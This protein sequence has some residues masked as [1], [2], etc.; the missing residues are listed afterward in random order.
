MKDKVDFTNIIQYLQKKRLDLLL[1]RQEQDICISQK[2]I[3]MEDIVNHSNTTELFKTD[4]IVKIENEIYE[5][6]TRLDEINAE[7]SQIDNFITNLNSNVQS[8]KDYNE[9]NDFKNSSIENG[10]NIILLQEEDRR[11]ISREL[12]DSPLQNLTYLVHKL[13]LCDLLMK[14]DP[15]KACHEIKNVS[16]NIKSIIN[17]IRDIIY[18]LRPMSFDDLG[19][20]DSV[21]FMLNRLNSNK[22]L[23]LNVTIDDVS[24]ENVYLINFYR[25]IQEAFINILKHSNAATATIEFK[26]ND[27]S[28]SIHIADDGDGFSFEMI[29]SQNYAHYGIVLLKERVSLLGGS[30][31]IESN[32][33]E[34]TFVDIIVKKEDIS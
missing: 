27:D 31:K 4:S 30:I 32:L 15:D 5:L 33:G 20:R 34:G 7:I 23:F 10:K 17:E 29:Q 22:K 19:F 2:Q 1:E 12:H 28:Y 25:I 3:E 6:I 8:Q 13:E 14:Q 21:M 26:E 16:S 9:Y 11:R 24:C 18:D